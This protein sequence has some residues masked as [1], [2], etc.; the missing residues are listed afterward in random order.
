MIHY[1]RLSNKVNINTNHCFAIKERCHL[2]LF[3]AFCVLL[4]TLFGQSYAQSSYDS[5]YHHGCNDADI[6]DPA[7]Q[8]INQPEKGP[9]FHS[10]EFMEA[11]MRVM[12]I[13]MTRL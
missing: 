3:S 8:Y 9:S 6:S 13:V 2:L 10:D 7:R 1:C 4:F 11:M 5:G 12:G